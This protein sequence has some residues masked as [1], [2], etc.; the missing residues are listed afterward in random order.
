MLEKGDL[1]G[2][3]QNLKK[4]LY[5]RGLTVSDVAKMA[6]IKKTTLYT[7]IQR[8]V[9]VSYGNAIKL[10]K[11]L[12]PVIDMRSICDEVPADDPSIFRTSL[13]EY[14]KVGEKMKAARER[15]DLG[16]KDT[17]NL[18][19]ISEE[20]YT[21]YEAEYKEPPMEVLLPF[22]GVIHKSL[23]ELLEIEI[24]PVSPITTAALPVNTFGQIRPLFNSDYQDTVII[25]FDGETEDKNLEISVQH[26]ILNTLEAATIQYITTL[27][28]GDGN[29]HI[30]ICLKQN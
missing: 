14:L 29:G 8:D 18:L 13:S 5:E 23:E 20:S 9:S 2:Y 27:P 25:V 24:A 4:I 16:I 3:G 26:P 12:H 30:A 10:Y 28:G 6:N 15:A 19:H 11:V 21:D 22:C 7:S 17:A 1:M